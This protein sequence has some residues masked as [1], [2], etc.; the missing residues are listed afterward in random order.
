VFAVVGAGALA[1]GLQRT[2]FLIALLVLGFAGVWILSG[3][4]RAKWLML[5]PPLSY[6]LWELWKTVPERFTP[7]AGGALH[8]LPGALGGVVLLGAL[9]ATVV[10]AAPKIGW[11]LPT[12]AGTTLVLDFGASLLRMAVLFKPDDLNGLI[13]RQVR[14]VGAWYG[15]LGGGASL[16][17]VC[18]VALALAPHAPTPPLR[19]RKLAIVGIAGALIAGGALRSVARG[20]PHD[21]LV[22]AL[23]VLALGALPVILGAVGVARSARSGL[24]WVGAVLVALQIVQLLVTAATVHAD[25]RI[26]VAMGFTLAP[27]GLA[28]VAFAPGLPLRPL[29][30]L[31]GAFFAA[32]VAGSLMENVGVLLDLERVVRIQGDPAQWWTYAKLGAPAMTQGLFVWS[33]LLAYL[34]APPAPAPAQGPT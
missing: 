4:D 30:W 18:W 16:V 7:A 17:A 3:V 1:E 19:S 22:V 9:L 21:T 20:L 28:L 23:E 12:L 32:S 25:D 10:A 6:A 5:A 29:R 2:P 15:D 34:V 13:V 14:G 33:A 8:A 31:A 27:L 24:A 26:I 11:G